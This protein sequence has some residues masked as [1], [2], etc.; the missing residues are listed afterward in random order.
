M[1]QS[2][3]FTV[4]ELMSLLVVV[5]GLIMLG[6]AGKNEVDA[7]SRDAHRKI[8]VNS[9]YYALKEGYFKTNHS[10]PPTIDAATLPYIDPNLFNDPS[11]R[12]VGLPRSDYHYKALGCEENVCQDFSISAKL[13]KEADYKKS[14]N[15]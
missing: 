15:D 12:K 5:I 6:V 3:G 1:K 8:A 2:Y 10:Y 7:S 13:E 9:F 11:G 14:G 4:I